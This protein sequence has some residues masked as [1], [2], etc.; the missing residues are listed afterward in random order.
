[1]VE[2]LGVMVVVLVVVLGQNK[3]FKQR[4]CSQILC[5][6]SP[7]SLPWLSDMFCL[8]VHSPYSYHGSVTCLSK[9]SFPLQFTMAQ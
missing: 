7:Y 6:H 4:T 9:G 5:F 1:M 3:L 2:G 8:R